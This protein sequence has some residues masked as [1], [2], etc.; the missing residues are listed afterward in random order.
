MAARYYLFPVRCPCTFLHCPSLAA[1]LF[2]AI[3]RF[4]AR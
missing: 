4:L 1:A 2:L 3:C